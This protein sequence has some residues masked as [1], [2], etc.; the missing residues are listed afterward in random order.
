MTANPKPAPRDDEQPLLP[1]GGLEFE[2][3]PEFLDAHFGLVGCPGSGKTLCIR[4]LIRAA[5]AERGRGTHVAVRHRALVYDPKRDAVPMLTGLGFSPDQIRVLNPFDARAYAWDMASDI[6][7][8]A[9]ARQLAAIIAPVPKDV[10]EPFFVEAAQNLIHGVVRTF[11]SACPRAWTLRDITEAVTSPA[12]LRGVLERSPDG[13]DL[14]AMFLDQDPRTTGSILATLVTRVSYYRTIAALW[15]RLPKERL[16]S[17]DRWMRVDG[18]PFILVLGTDKKHSES[19]DPINRVLFRRAAELVVSRHEEYPPDQSWFFVDEARVAGKLDGLPDLLLQ[20]RSKSARVV[21]GFQD[22]EGMRDVY[23]RE[24]ANELLAMCGNLAFLRLQSNES[25]KWAADFAGQYMAW[26]SSHTSGQNFGR[27]FSYSSSTTDN[28]SFIP[29]LLPSELR[30][31]PPANLEDG[32]PGVFAV[33]SAGVWKG[34]IERAFLET[35][36]PEVYSDTTP[37]A[38]G[39]A[40]R[41]AADQERLPWK[42]DDER[43]LGFKPSGLAASGGE[44]NEDPPS[45]LE[46]FITPSFD[47]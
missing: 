36:L 13:L 10:R 44:D 11:Q 25:A 6:L 31:L 26:Q 43:R 24:V 30:G 27:D 28:L 2:P 15:A 4:M 9:G 42:E 47:E 32:I 1:W 21:L 5:L 3:G 14:A 7:D 38:P 18:E 8:D 23:G 12:R 17:L 35:H 33:P 40:P 29:S 39:F 16:V 19:L 41:D 37:T 46:G 45:T 22:I 20:G 34:V